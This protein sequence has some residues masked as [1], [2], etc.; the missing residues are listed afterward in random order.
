MRNTDI[1]LSNT[2]PE[3]LVIRNACVALPNTQRGA[4]LVLALLILI[5]IIMHGIPTVMNNTLNERMSGNTRNRDLAFQAAEHALKAA[6]AVLFNSGSLVRQYI[7]AYIAGTTLPSLPTGLALNGETHLNT[8]TYWR[9]TFA[10]YSDSDG[11]VCNYLSPSDLPNQAEIGYYAA[12]CYVI[13]RM[14]EGCVDAATPPGN[15]CPADQYKHY[16]R[17]TARGVGK[18]RD[19]I[20]ILQAMYEFSE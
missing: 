18:E 15:P 9:D 10:W 4:T 12:P 5:M 1:A 8:A 11:K 6:D 2:Q 17:V 19:A 3:L 20:V 13:E 14:T 7:D 16:Y